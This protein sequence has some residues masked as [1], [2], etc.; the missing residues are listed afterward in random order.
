MDC[1]LGGRPDGQ[2]DAAHAARKLVRPLT[3]GRRTGPISCSTQTRGDAAVRAGVGRSLSAVEAGLP[4]SAVG[5]AERGD[6][7]YLARSADGDSRRWLRRLAAPGRS[8]ARAAHQSRGAGARLPARDP[9]RLGLGAP[10]RELQRRR[11]LGA[12]PTGATCVWSSAFG[13]LPVFGASALG[14]SRNPGCAFGLSDIARDDDPHCTNQTS[15]PNRRSPTVPPVSTALGVAACALGFEP[16]RRHP[17]P[18]GLPPPRPG[19]PVRAVLVW[20]ERVRSARAT[21]RR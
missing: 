19:P 12:A 10:W 16:R 2:P 11:E 1:R 4:L 15:P 9:C 8:H 3:A 5:K 17:D 20:H 14:R 21:E 6:G 13:G 7:T 18:D